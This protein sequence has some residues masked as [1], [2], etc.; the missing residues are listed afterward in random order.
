MAELRDGGLFIVMGIP[1]A[2]LDTATITAI[3][4]IQPSGFILFGR[5]I[6]TPEQVRALTDHLRELVDHEPIIT[7]DQEGGRVSRLRELKSG[8]RQAAEPPSA[9]QLRAKKNLKLIARHGELTGKLLRLFGFNL[10]LCPVLDLSFE[11]DSANSLRFRTW[12]ETAEEVISQ[13]RAFNTA[14]RD[15]GILTCGKHFPGYSRVQADP[16]QNLPTVQRTRA[17]LQS[18]EWVPF[19]KMHHELDMMM[20]GHV[21]YPELDPQNPGSLSTKVIRDIL[22]HE[23]NYNGVVVSDDLDMDAVTLFCQN[24]F[25]ASACRAVE[26]GNDLILICHRIPKV[27]EAAEALAELPQEIRDAARKRIEKV[28]GLLAPPSDFSLEKWEEI[29]DEIQ[30]LRIDTLGA[31]APARSDES[32][33]RSAVEQVGMEQGYLGR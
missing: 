23:W 33:K 27:R 22:R 3:E 12:G 19:Q 11:E 10:D 13:A 29:D 21:I 1:G 26:A 9:S 8:D 5:N 31:N 17:E 32:A 18:E 4:E 14:L 24:D 15:E 28:R 2:K 6:Q 30:Q 20:S 7:I 25:R 16:H